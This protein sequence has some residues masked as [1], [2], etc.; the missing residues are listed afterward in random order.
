MF[1]LGATDGFNWNDR[2]ASSLEAAGFTVVSPSNA[3]VSDGEVTLS[4]TKNSNSPGNA[5]RIAALASGTHCVFAVVDFNGS[6]SV[7]REVEPFTVSSPCST[8]R[9]ESYVTGSGSV[10]LAW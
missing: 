1:P 5:Y 3:A 2:M 4:G 7:H 8:V 9:V 6:V 10:S